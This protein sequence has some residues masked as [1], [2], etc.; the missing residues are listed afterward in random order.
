MSNLALELHQMA[1]RAQAELDARLA[2]CLA[3]ADGGIT[4]SITEI[5]EPH[6]GCP[7][8]GGEDTS[9][10]GPCIATITS[11]D[12]STPLIAHP[13]T[14]P[15][16][17]A[18]RGDGSLS[19]SLQAHDLDPSP[20]CPRPIPLVRST[21]A[22][23]RAS[24]P[25]PILI[26]PLRSDLQGRGSTPSEPGAVTRRES[27][28]SS[29][30]SSTGRRI[31]LTE[32]DW[33]PFVESH[34][35]ARARVQLNALLSSARDVHSQR[36]GRRSGRTPASLRSS[37]EDSLSSSG[38]TPNSRSDLRLHALS[39]HA[40]HSQAH[41]QIHTRSHVR[42]HSSTTVTDDE[43]KFPASVVT[44]RDP[45]HASAT[46]S[47]DDTCF[48][49]TDS[50]LS[51]S[52]AVEEPDYWFE[53][54]FPGRAAS[55]SEWDWRRPTPQR[56]RQE[57]CAAREAARRAGVA[58]RSPG[59]SFTSVPDERAS[60]LP[61]GD[62]TP[63]LDQVA[64]LLLDPSDDDWYSTSSHSH[65]HPRRSVSRIVSQ[66]SAAAAVV[67]SSAQVTQP[68]PHAAR[69]RRRRRPAQP[70][71]RPWA[72]DSVCP[73][74]RLSATRARGTAVCYTGPARTLYTRTMPRP[75]LRALR[76]SPSG[77]RPPRREMPHR[78][79]VPH[80]PPPSKCRHHASA[81]L[82]AP[83]PLDPGP[84]TPSPAKNLYLSIPCTPPFY[85]LWVL[86][87]YCCNPVLSPLYSVLIAFHPF[88][89]PHP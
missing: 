49:P 10:S 16:R 87:L 47:T 22:Q 3:R 5:D 38:L 14:V 29:Q 82:K 56:L 42:S 15:L 19:H 65:A 81:A 25:D 2:R 54:F 18:R 28:S 45:S 62:D 32:P 1:M 89:T 43:P 66:A 67:A 4:E 76:L 26:S 80:D 88:R 86:S 55:G 7:D 77:S 73:H 84:S 9:S 12:P 75:T 40:L 11:T 20:S 33:Q 34:A 41:A 6:D 71:W 35:R 57:R 36:I 39:A 64:Q 70:K 74:A 63:V 72:T 27:Y 37:L 48:S 31:R 46:S 61:D 8:S 79:F 58:C 85:G 30:G 52:S 13:I 59:S 17:P 83:V 53:R 51:A 68:E 44:R 21:T 23:R 50:A 24:A 69:R 60:P 78:P